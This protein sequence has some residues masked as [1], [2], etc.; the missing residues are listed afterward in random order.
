MFLEGLNRRNKTVELRIQKDSCIYRMSAGRSLYITSL[1]SS[2]TWASSWESYEYVKQQLES[3]GM[4]PLKNDKELVEICADIREGLVKRGFIK[5]GS[6]N[7]FY[8]KHVNRHIFNFF[9]RLEILVRTVL[10]PLGFFK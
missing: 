8:A 10:R 5:E 3:E 1:L 7:T 6:V 9:E 2:P 4:P